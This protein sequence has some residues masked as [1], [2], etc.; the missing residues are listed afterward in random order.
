[1]SPDRFNLGFET[2]AFAG[3]FR[4]I[5][6]IRASAVVAFRALPDGLGRSLPA[7]VDGTGHAFRDRLFKPNG[8]RLGLTPTA[9]N[10]RTGYKRCGQNEL[11]APRAYPNA[12]Q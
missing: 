7:A 5:L 3:T 10:R 8:C 6:A 2:R 12:L 4:R 9:R 1:L 11:N